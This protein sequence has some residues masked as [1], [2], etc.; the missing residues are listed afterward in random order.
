MLLSDKTNDNDQ[1]ETCAMSLDGNNLTDE[2]T[3]AIN[4]ILYKINKDNCKEYE[5]AKNKIETIKNKLN[6]I[7]KTIKNNTELNNNITKVIVSCSEEEISFDIHLNYNYFLLLDYDYI[8]EYFI[9]S[10]TKVNNFDNVYDIILGSDEEKNLDF[11]TEIGEKYKKNEKH[12]KGEVCKP[13]TLLIAPYTE[14]SGLLRTMPLT[15][16]L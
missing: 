14:F 15:M 9:F 6:N 4:R 11:I 12:I 1:T 5:P 2:L 8:N 7:Y 13:E 10:L 16:A 3:K